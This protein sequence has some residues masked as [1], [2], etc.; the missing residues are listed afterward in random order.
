MLTLL[1]ELDGV[2][3]LTAVLNKDKVYIAQRQQKDSLYFFVANMVLDGL[4]NNA[5]I[6]AGGTIHIV[7]DRK[8]T[9]KSLQDN[10][11]GLLEE[12]LN[13]AY[14]GKHSVT[15]CASHESKSLQAVDFVSWA[16]FQKYQHGDYS[17]YEIIRDCI[18]DER[19]VFP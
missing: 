17:F 5:L 11:V 6:T 19:V 8:D 7:A 10:F 3:I 9:K 16:L 15:L 2:K 12:S 4:Y 13:T 18:V 1:A 14:P